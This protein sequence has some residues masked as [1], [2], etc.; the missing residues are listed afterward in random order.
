MA[1]ARP[2]VNAAALHERFWTQ[3]HEYMANRDPSIKLG[4]PSNRSLGKEI[5]GP[6]PI[7]L[8]L[9]NVLSGTSGIWVRLTGQALNP[10]S[11]G[12]TIGFAVSSKSN[13]L[14]SVKSSGSPKT[15]KEASSA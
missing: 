1:R 7:R 13:S 3:F 12:S 6:G 11:T 5:P 4:K 8:V 9:W 2:R 15:A 10:G 14:R